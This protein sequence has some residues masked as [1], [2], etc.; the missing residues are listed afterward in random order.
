[1]KNLENLGR[2]L[3]EK[4]QR[5]INGGACTDAGKLSCQANGGIWLQALGRPVCVGVCWCLSDNMM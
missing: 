1:M 4:E 3:T 5:S 2:P